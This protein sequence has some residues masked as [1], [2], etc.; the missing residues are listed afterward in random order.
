MTKKKQNPS[1]SKIVTIILFFGAGLVL[2]VVVL[3]AY[4]LNHMG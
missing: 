4:I 2:A 3:S 1:Y